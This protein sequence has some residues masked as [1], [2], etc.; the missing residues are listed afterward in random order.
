M[1]STCD[2]KIFRVG[3]LRLSTSRNIKVAIHFIFLFQRLHTDADSTS[4]VML[5]AIKM[6]RNI[7]QCSIMQIK[8]ELWNK[9][10]I[11]NRPIMWTVDIEF[12]KKSLVTQKWSSSVW[13]YPTK[14][15][16]PAWR[17]HL[18]RI[19]SASNVFS[20][21]WLKSNETSQRRTK[22][23]AQ[24]VSSCTMRLYS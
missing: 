16:N 24:V 13:K 5:S 9:T 15:H 1:C 23:V 11:W 19:N 6:S 7:L 12:K 14:Q 2:R 18:P 10:T 3:L 17:P 20:R 22:R 8:L 4:Q 21:E